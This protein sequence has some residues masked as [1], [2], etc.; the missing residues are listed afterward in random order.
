MP[1][2]VRC[3][4]DECALTSQNKVAL[5][6][7]RSAAL[8]SCVLRNKYKG[9]MAAVEDLVRGQFMSATIRCPALGEISTAVCRGW[10][11]L[12]K[13]YSNETSER[14]RMNRACRACARNKVTPQAPEKETR[15]V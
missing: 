9:D 1:D 14:V 6:L 8:V 3:L 5:R 15:N 2:Y 10:M 12:A 13:T 11:T 4:A 7:G